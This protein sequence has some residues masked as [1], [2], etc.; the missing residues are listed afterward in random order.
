[1]YRYFK[2]IAGVGNGNYIY[3][4]KS[5]GLSDERINSITTSNYSINPELSHYGTKIRI[6]FNR[7]CLKQDKFTYSHGT[8]VNI[9][10][11]YEISKSYNISSYPTLENCLFGAVSLT[12]HADIDQ[13][14]YSRYGIGFDRKGEFAFGSNGTKNILVLGKDFIQGLDNT[15]IYAEKLHSVNVTKTNTKLCLSLHYNGGNSY[16]IVNGTEIHK[17]KAKNFEILVTP[18]CLRNISKD[19]SIDNMKKTGLNGYVYDFSVDYDAIAV[20]DILNIHKYL[21][22]KLL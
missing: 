14:K 13:Y 21:M 10:I 22:E 2:R 7:S 8:I 3:F 4:W 12:K 17:F 20:D 1:M 19:F 16:L 5:K 6:K 18:L 15:T 11:V 9:Y